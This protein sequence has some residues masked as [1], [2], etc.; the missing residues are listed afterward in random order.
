MRAIYKIARLEL[1]NLF[2]SPIAWLVL[3]LFVFM[4][5]MNFTDVLW[6]YARSQEF[7]GG[8][9]SDLSRTLFF[10]MTGRGLWPK[11]TNLLYMI[12]PLL[13]MGLISQE[14]SR[15]SIKLLFVAPITSRH[16]VLGKFLGMLMYG[17]VMFVVLLVYVVLAGCW[18]E[19]FD[20]AAVLTGLL[21]LYL[22]FATYAAIGLFMSTLTSYPIVAA[23][24]MLALLTFLRFVSGLWQEYTFVR[25]ITYWLALDRRAGT[26]INGMICSEDFLYFVI[27]TTMFL[28]FAVLKLQF[29]RER[30]SLLSKVGRFL[31]V[32]VIAMLLGYVTSRPMLRLYYDSTHTKSNTLT[33]ASQ[34]IVSKLDGGL[35]ITTYVN[36]FGSV[37]NITPAKVMTDIA[38]YNS[39]IRFKPEIEMDY[40]FYYYTDTT[41]GY[42]QQRFP[43]KTLKEAAKE[44][45]KFQGVNVNKY[46]PLSKIDT[47]VDLRDEAYR[48]VALLE[49]ESG[50]KTFLRVF[51]DA[52]RVPFETEISAALKRITMKLPT[53]GFLSDHRARTITGDRNRDYSY[54]VSE[55]LFRTAL[56][57]QGF[58]V[59]DVKLSRDPRLLDHLDILVIA[60]PM[61][62]F[63]D[64][65]LDMLFRYVESGKN[66]ILA[67]KPK[68]NGYLKPLMDRL[69]LAFEAGILVQGQDQVE[70]GRADGPS[71][72]GSLPS[73]GSTKQEVEREYPVS[74]YLC[75][76]TNEAKDLSRL[77]SVLYRQTRAPEWPYAIVM[78]GASAINQVEDK[79]FQVTPLLIG[80]DP[81][82]WNELETI[83][84]INEIPQL[85]TQAGE[86]SGVKT[87][88]MALEREQAGKQQRV[89][90]IGD[91]DAF[92]M[93][94][95]M[96]NRRGILSANG[97]LI[98]SMFEWLSYGELPI[99]TSRPN[100]IDNTMTIG[101]EGAE[102]VKT[103]LQWI[104][105]AL[106]LLGG[107]LL[108]IRR[109]GK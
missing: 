31:G 17:V 13:T 23:I 86:R 59:A 93:G 11:V 12:M 72:R 4:T 75:K 100:P 62:P 54:M 73:P 97:G 67:G 16:I 60:E 94:E 45:A 32:F 42:F 64:T 70:K 63:T 34:D 103:I 83:D 109:K 91:A 95:V 1:S 101:A 81:T 88:M 29:I 78:P 24:Y 104:L 68:T 36:L 19:S 21:G 58:D 44:M 108:L 37:Y 87:T 102:S 79:G 49:R 65:E 41:D 96:A 84:F 98:M 76:V 50:E 82:G 25:E 27:M 51:Q 26:F 9:L 2:Y 28:G 80:G 47:E 10:D 71:V 5:A 30:R 89:V 43:H 20:W 74:L 38:R 48:F 14:F 85:N 6:G 15:G 107:V 18:I 66:L 90:V 69:G 39:Y 33:Q 77:W 92:S 52:Q 40:V 53:V 106:I 61:E 46:V 8:G 3:I 56:I 55:K 35:K 105:P 7:R 99:D 57:N 22:L